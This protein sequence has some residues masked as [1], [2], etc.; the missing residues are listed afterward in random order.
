[1]ALKGQKPSAA[2][3]TATAVKVP[4]K[5]QS[6]RKG[7]NATAIAPQSGQQRLKRPASTQSVNSNERELGLKKPRRK[8]LLDDDDV[9]EFGREIQ[10][11]GERYTDKHRLVRELVHENESLRSEV[12][13]QN[14][15][16]KQHDV[17]LQNQK[18]KLQE[19]AER[20]HDQDEKLQEQEGKLHNQEEKL[21]SQKEKILEEKGR[22]HDQESKLADQE[23]K[24]LDQQSK[25]CDQEK[26]LLVQDEKLRD[27]E[28]KLVVDGKS[29]HEW[30][31]EHR[32]LKIERDHAYRRL[33]EHFSD[34]HLVWTDIRV[35]WRHVCVTNVVVF[36]GQD[37]E[38]PDEID[39]LPETASASSLA[40]EMIEVCK[41]QPRIKPIWVATRHI[42]RRLMRDVFSEETRVWK[43]KAGQYLV[44]LA[45]C[46]TGKLMADGD[47]RDRSAHRRQ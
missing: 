1:M 31:E 44:G 3:D 37:L 16:I 12:T 26:K 41:D 24:L 22:I 25:L 20:I 17:K 6:K 30:R 39:S 19:Q 29:C 27:Q 10:S 40:A 8:Q 23:S 46:F 38:I 35:P 47:E 43:G 13:A 7:G 14:D 9:V 11:L 18:E 32:S 28:S 42:L 21:Q 5:K 34:G 45:R 33:G 15:E 2:K 36:V 4:Q